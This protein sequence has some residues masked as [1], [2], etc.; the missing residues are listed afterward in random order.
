[1][2]NSILYPFILFPSNYIVETF[3]LKI[4]TLTGML[5]IDFYRLDVDMFGVSNKITY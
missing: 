5:F 4:G 2:C 1:M 3:G